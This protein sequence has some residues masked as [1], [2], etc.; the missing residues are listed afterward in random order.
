MREFSETELLLE[1]EP[2]VAGELDRHHA[3]AK[4]WFPHEYV[5][6]SE[7]RTST[8]S[9]AA[10]PGPSDSKIS[11]RGPDR[12]ARQPADRGQPP[13]L[14]P[15]DR[16]DLGPRRRLG[17]WVHRW[18][19][20]EGRHGVAI[21]DYLTVTRAVDPVAL[22]RARMEHMG[23][24]FTNYDDGVLASLA[25]VS[26]QELATRVSH[27]NT[28][29]A[30]GDPNCEQTARPHRRRREPAHDLLPQ[31]AQRGLRARPRP[32]HAGDHR[33]GHGLPDARHHDRRLPRKSVAI[34]NAGIYDLRLHH[35]DVLMPVLR[36]W[37]VFE[38]KD[39]DAEGE[40]ARHELAE[41][42][43]R[44]EIAAARFVE[45]REARRARQA[46]GA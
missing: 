43:G 30:S 41:F 23:E 27:R 12:A 33:G 4:E 34:A 2:V 10:R 7:G 36:K 28:G 14:P 21:R 13:E 6:W 15:R 39:L 16:H 26:F 40:K 29:K 3:V 24:G 8:A 25:Y 31:P 46:A 44:I 32:D 19:A 42:L 9:S 38:M 22:E 20:E 5:P 35:D 45:R 17:H 1:L 18:T 37:G 11:P